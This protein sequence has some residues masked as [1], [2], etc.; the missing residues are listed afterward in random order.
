MANHPNRSMRERHNWLVCD[1]HVCLYSE[2]GMER[3]KSDP[4]RC[5]KHGAI[6]SWASEYQGMTRPEV[7]AKRA[8]FVKYMSKP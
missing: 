3:L 8:D 4:P 5:V 1:R 2:R 7:T 6:L